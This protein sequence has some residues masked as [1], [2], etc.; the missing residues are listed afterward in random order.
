[1]PYDIKQTIEFRDWLMG[2]K[3]PLA[4][5]RIIAR[6]TRFSQGNFGDCKNLGDQLLE[7]RF[8]FGPGFRVYF[9]IRN[10][11]LILLLLGGDKSSQ[12]QDISKARK[13]IEEYKDV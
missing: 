11:T 13:L 4:Q 12:S 2:M 7:A 6:I 8:F 9:T 10:N 5:Q 1:M 3:D